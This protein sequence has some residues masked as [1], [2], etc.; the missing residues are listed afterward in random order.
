MNFYFL[1]PYT[2]YLVS[3]FLHFAVFTV[4]ILFAT[5]QLDVPYGHRRK[6]GP[7]IVEVDIGSAPAAKIA[8]ST[9]SEEIYSNHGEVV[10]KAKKNKKN[11]QEAT[12]E[13]VNKDESVRGE[14]GFLNGDHIGGELGDERG[15]KVS[16]KERYLY[17]LR[18]LIEGRKF[19]PLVSRRLGES[20]K[21]IVEFTVDKEGAINNVN[22]RVPS[23]FHRLNMAAQQL[24]SGIK[25]YKPLPEDFSE[26]EARLEVPIDYSLN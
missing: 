16:A 3:A 20:G 26:A 12:T 7:M 25:R 17:E 23:E 18:V 6:G 8:Q 15:R 2:A 22:L 21:V 19:Y 14:I 5:K 13:A 9:L 24:V 1:K 4:T 11:D 10:V